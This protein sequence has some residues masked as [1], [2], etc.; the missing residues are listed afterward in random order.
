MSHTIHIAR[1][2]YKLMSFIER[3]L[4][5]EP[6]QRSNIECFGVAIIAFTYFGKTLLKS[7]R[8]GFK[9]V[10]GFKYVSVL[11]TRFF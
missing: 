6:Y 1:S 10:L 9:Y 3:L 8:G 2:L 11:N 5:S 7:V 4:Y